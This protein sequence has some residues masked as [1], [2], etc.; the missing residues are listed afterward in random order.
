MWRIATDEITWSVCWVTFVSP[1][2]TAE[3]IEMR[4]GVL[5]SHGPKKP[6]IIWGRDPPPEWATLGGYLAH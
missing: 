5:D 3:P 1:A 2:K 6:C 4:F